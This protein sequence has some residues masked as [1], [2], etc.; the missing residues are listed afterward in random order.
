MERQTAWRRAH[1]GRI[2]ERCTPRILAGARPSRGLGP[3]AQPTTR[4]STAAEMQYNGVT[5]LLAREK[6]P[7][8]ARANGWRRT[9]TLRR[10]PQLGLIALPAPP[11]CHPPAAPNQCSTGD[12]GPIQRG[13]APSTGMDAIHAPVMGVIANLALQQMCPQG[14]SDLHGRRT[15]ELLPARI[16]RARDETVQKI[17]GSNL[18]SNRCAIVNT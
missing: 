4:T 11:S 8:R 2:A 9:P 15:V 3:G 5:N 14:F 10:S 16:T 7:G 18:H 17:R 1:L 13:A 12:Q 6:S